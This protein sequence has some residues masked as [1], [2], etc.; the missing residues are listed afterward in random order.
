[1]ADVPAPE[2]TMRGLCCCPLDH[3]HAPYRRDRDGEVWIE[4]WYCGQ[5]ERAP[6]NAEP[7][8]G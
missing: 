5:Q 2:I 8:D 1:M 7:S 3:G 4:C 6:E